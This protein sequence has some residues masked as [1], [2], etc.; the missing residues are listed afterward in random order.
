MPII[1]DPT[2]L[3]SRRSTQYP[4]P[5]NQGFDKRV[6]WPLTEALGLSQFGINLVTLEPGGQSSHRHWHAREDECIYVLA[7]EIT[8]VLNDGERVLTAGAVAGF[9]AGDGN[10]HH[11]LNRSSAPATY[12]EIGTRSRDDDITYPDVDLKAVIRG[13]VLTFL[14]KSGE[15]Y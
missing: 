6:K 1:E 3:P 4:A 13:D 5:L 9:P 12:L 7:G 2:S 15:P 10:G 11:L 8:L 14:R